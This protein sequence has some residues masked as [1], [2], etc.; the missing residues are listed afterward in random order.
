MKIHIDQTINR[1]HHVT[2]LA[3]DPQRNLDFYAGVLGFRLV[4]R[5]LNFD[6]PDVYH[7]YYGDETG[8]PGTIL[9]SYPFIDAVRGR[10]VTSEIFAGAFS[11]PKGS[12][13]YWVERLSSNGIHLDGPFERFGDEVI[14]FEDRDGM[15]IELI[16][17]DMLS[18]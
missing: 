11:I 17:S 16:V 2:A 14:A 9:S 12:L 3:S 1:I 10:R 13:E 4:K 8:H 18:S 6:T 7:F 15:M 5:T